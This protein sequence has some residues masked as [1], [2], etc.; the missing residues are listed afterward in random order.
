MLEFV[1]YEFLTHTV[2]FGKES[3]FSK[4]PGSALSEGLGPKV[5]TL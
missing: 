4:G 2:K 1:G 5:C 3:T